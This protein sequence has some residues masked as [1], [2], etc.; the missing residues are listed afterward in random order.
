MT[1]ENSRQKINKVSITD[2]EKAN[3]MIKT[4][5]RTTEIKKTEQR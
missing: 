1:E 2:F 3:E 5:I 4:F